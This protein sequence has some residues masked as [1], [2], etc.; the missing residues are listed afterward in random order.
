MSCEYHLDVYCNYSSTSSMYSLP[1]SRNRSRKLTEDLYKI[2]Y[3]EN[4]YETLPHVDANVPKTAFD[5]AGDDVDEDRHDTSVTSAH[6]SLDFS[7][8]LRPN[9]GHSSLN[10]DGGYYVM[11]KNLLMDVANETRL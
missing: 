5:K 2:E 1:D 7:D 9:G 4:A 6:H 10:V 8:L 3:E 11:R